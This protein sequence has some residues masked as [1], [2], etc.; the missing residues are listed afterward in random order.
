MNLKAVITSLVLATSSVAVAKPVYQIDPDADLS[1]RDQR[2]AWRPTWSPLSA[3][4]TAG[5]RTTI[6]VTENRRTDLTAIRLQNVSG[7]TYIY[8]MVLVYED[9]HRETLDVSKWLYGSQPLLTFDLKQNH[10]RLDKILMRTW[11]GYGNSQFQVFGK[12]MRN[13][14]RPPIVNPPHPSLPPAPVGLVIGTNLTFANTNGY[15]HVPV[16]ADKGRFTKLQ[17]QSTGMPLIGKVFVTYTTGAHQMF[18][19]NRTLS[20]G[21]NLDLDLNGTAAL[22]IAS[23]T[24]MAGNDV[25]AVG[26]SAGRFNI[27]LF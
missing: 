24:V 23:I 11:A 6:D 22:S 9:G 16:G 4:I 20:R 27:A 5:R 14:G 3:K 2:G 12:T 21:E 18:D 8:S 15:V 10:R 26:P 25:R 1:F 13:I 19:V 7:A 17:I